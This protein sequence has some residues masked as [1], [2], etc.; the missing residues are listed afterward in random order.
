M[1]RSQWLVGFPSKI[2]KSKL[3]IGLY[4]MTKKLGFK[5][6]PSLAFGHATRTTAFKKSV[7]ICIVA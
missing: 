1:K 7:R 4:T 3:A 2:K 5:P 6:R